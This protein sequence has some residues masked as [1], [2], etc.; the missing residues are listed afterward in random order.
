MD[1]INNCAC[2]K[3]SIFFN[4][5]FFQKWELQGIEAKITRDVYDLLMYVPYRDVY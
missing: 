5:F 3:V 1:E 2:Y 4:N